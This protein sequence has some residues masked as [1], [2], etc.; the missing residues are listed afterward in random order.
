MS[1]FMKIHSAV[2]VLLHADGQ[3]DMAKLVRELLQVLVAN[4]LK[5]SVVIQYTVIQ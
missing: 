2:L 3:T 4:A 5:K 1:N